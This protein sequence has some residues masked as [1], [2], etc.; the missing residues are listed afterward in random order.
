MISNNYLSNKQP[1]LP[2]IQENNRLSETESCTLT[3]K[4][5][6]TNNLSIHDNSDK[7]GSDR[8]SFHIP[9]ENT[10]QQHFNTNIQDQQSNNTNKE[11][12]HSKSPIKLS[13][14]GSTFNNSNKKIWWKYI[15]NS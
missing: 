7:P 8:P 4:Q 1:L 13:P 6:L 3:I 15:K 11:E 5:N 14:L 10:A 9:S 2:T 12:E